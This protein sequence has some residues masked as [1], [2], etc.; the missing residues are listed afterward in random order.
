VLPLLYNLMQ[1][2]VPYLRNHSRSNIPSFRACSR[3]LASLSE[4]QYTRKSWKKEGMELLLDPQFFQMDLQ[5]L[6]HWRCT[7]DNLMTHD[8]T[9]FKELMVKIASINQSGSLN[10]F[11]SKDV[12]LEQRTLLL[13]RLAFVIY[14]SNEDQYQKQMP[15]I[16]ERLA[17]SLR[18]IPSSPGVQSAV[19]LCFRVILIRMSPQHVTSLW[20]LIITEMVLIFSYLE[21]ELST[22]SEEW[23]THLKRMSTLDSSWVVSAGANGLAAHNSPSWLGLYLSVCKLLDLSLALPA[24]KLP[25]FQMYRWA[26]VSEGMENNN[27][28]GLEANQLQNTKT[29]HSLMNGDK[30]ETIPNADKNSSS[31]STNCQK[32]LY[33]QDFVPY[34]VRVARLLLQ[35]VE[36]VKPVILKSGEPQLTMTTILSLDDLAGF[37]AALCDGVTRQQTRAK[38]QSISNST[39]DAFD[40]KKYYVKD[41]DI[42]TISIM[43]AIL[44]RDFL[45]SVMK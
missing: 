17:E 43:D 5:S 21:Q 11:S 42:S 38:P 37:F 7:V 45:E 8:K 39:S 23:S 34:V 10:L 44:E 13:K 28:D 3:L 4:Y 20:P 9:T 41:N 19:F 15:D 14:C 35:K 30:S 31:T 1:N 16:Q 2:V 32:Q 26:F 24:H 33:Q 36:K 25:Q 12:E 27:V 22:D 40:P 29:P 6:Q 18:T